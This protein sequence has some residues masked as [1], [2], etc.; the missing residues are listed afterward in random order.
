MS[1]KS[2]DSA[3]SKKPGKTILE[4]RAEKRAKTAGS[5]NIFI[6]PRKSRR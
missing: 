5:E 2:P 1:G 4:K 6:K 3:K